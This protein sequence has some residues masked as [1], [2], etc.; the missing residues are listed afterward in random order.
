MRIEKNL[1][2]RANRKMLDS[3]RKLA[4]F[5]G[6]Q[7]LEEN[8]SRRGLTIGREISDIKPELDKADICR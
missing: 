7:R 4:L 3:L 8:L 6:F 1:S 5:V 2:G